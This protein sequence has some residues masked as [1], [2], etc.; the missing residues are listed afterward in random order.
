MLPPKAKTYFDNLLSASN[1]EAWS[2]LTQRQKAFERGEFARGISPDGAGF[3][4]RLAALYADSLTARAR[5]I[6]EILKIVH[7]AF[8]SP[9]NDGV[10]SQLRD[11]GE[12]ALSDAYQGLEGGYVRHLQR[13][14][15]DPAHATGLSHAYASARVV[16]GN[17]PSS[18]LWELRNVPAKRPQSPSASSTA[19]VVINNSGTIVALQTGANSTTN[20]QQQWGG[21]DSTE[22]RAA[23]TALRNA[24][25]RAQDVEAAQR[26][27]LIADVDSAVAEL[28]QENPNKGRLL[29][30][31]GGVGAAVQTV[32]SVQPAYAA[33]QSLARV[34]GLSL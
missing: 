31:L 2:D 10:D 7:Q 21:G 14:G 22:L 6:G 19:P 34:L 23:L 18:Y 33:V 26:V 1:A 4:A 3:V 16:V 9:L 25:E 32:A 29:R 27:D 30:C 24:L 20:V 8:D 13:Y 17:L 5:A 11:W 12:R 15:V 28:E